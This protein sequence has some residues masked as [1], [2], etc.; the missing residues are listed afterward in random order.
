MLSR[1]GYRV[2]TAD[3]GG[4]AL[5][6]IEERGNE[7][8]LFLADV[9]LPKIPGHKVAAFAV[10]HFRTMAVLFISGYPQNDKLTGRSRFPNS[11]FLAKPFTAEELLMTV[12]AL[13]DAP[14]ARPPLEP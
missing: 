12:R 1:A 7:I 13:V 8:D 14:L 9:V 2:V 11:S 10:E 4:E 6:V 5:E 3:D